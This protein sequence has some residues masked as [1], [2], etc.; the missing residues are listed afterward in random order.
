MFS[1]SDE[2]Y[3]VDGAKVHPKVMMWIRFVALPGSSA[4]FE[5]SDFCIYFLLFR[6]L[7]PPI[8]GYLISVNAVSELFVC[9]GNRYGRLGLVACSISLV[10]ARAGVD[11]GGECLGGLHGCLIWL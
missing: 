8:R 2:L 6:G 5:L 11:V 7:C 9:K 4:D 10:R 3:D 1:G